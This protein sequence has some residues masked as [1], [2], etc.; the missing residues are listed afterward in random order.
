MFDY[1]N[2]IKFLSPELI[3]I[4]KKDVIYPYVYNAKSNRPAAK[5]TWGKPFRNITDNTQYYKA[6]KLVKPEIHWYEWEPYYMMINIASIH[7]KCSTIKLSLCQSPSG[8]IRIVPS[9]LAR[10]IN[11]YKNGEDKFIH[12]D[13]LCDIVTSR[14][15]KDKGV[16]EYKVKQ[17]NE[18]YA[19][20]LQG[21]N[22]IKSKGW[23][24]ERINCVYQRN[25][26]IIIELL[27]KYESDMS[28]IHPGLHQ[29][30]MNEMLESNSEICF[31]DWKFIEFKGVKHEY[32]KVY[33][34]KVDRHL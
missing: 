17:R 18:S 16:T 34:N 22:I 1:K 8:M 31:S 21:L 19:L 4:L 15:L 27:E 28:L 11:Y 13:N 26:D 33:G 10:I 23:Y 20:Y 25:Y 5:T 6:L 32:K 29:E 7:Y 30:M 3:E 14:N 2:S 9:P 12:N 24:Y